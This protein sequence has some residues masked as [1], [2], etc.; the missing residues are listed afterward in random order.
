[1]IAEA[2]AL[3]DRPARAARE[4][5][6]LVA[7]T[8]DQSPVDQRQQLFK[9]YGDIGD[10][11][12]KEAL[13][14]LW[15]RKWLIIFVTLLVAGATAAIVYAMTPLYTSSVRLMF[16]QPRITILPGL[17]DQSPATEQMQVIGSRVVAE[18]VIDRLDLRFDPEFN[19]DLQ[20]E[21][22]VAEFIG[23]IRNFDLSAWV[24]PAIGSG[25]EI[26]RASDSEQPQI[27]PIPDN[28]LR[29][30]LV[31]EQ[32]VDAFL[33]RLTVDTVPQSNV[34][35]IS[36]ASLQPAK[37]AEIADAIANAYL[38]HRLE[39]KFE[40]IQRSSNWLEERIGEL[41]TQV[42]QAET[43]LEDYRR[44]SGLTESARGGEGAERQVAELNTQLILAR[45]DRAEREARRD[46][47]RRML[48]GGSE[49]LTRAAE[50]LNSPLVNSLL[51][52]QIELN[53]RVA[54]LSQIYGGRHPQLLSARAELEDM[55]QKIQQEARRVAEGL[56]AEV[57][58][59]RERERRLEQGL[60]E[61]ESSISETQQASVMLRAL[62]REANAARNLLETFLEQAQ[63][64]RSQ[65]DIG[66]QR[67]DA[68]IIAAAAIP[69]F[70]SYPRKTLALAA[71]IVVGG[72]LGVLLALLLERFDS[73]FRSAEQLEEMLGLPV[74][75]SIPDLRRNRQVRKRGLAAYLV[76]RPNS[77]AAEAIRALN[78][79]MMH[80][81]GDNR[82]MVVQFVSAE[83]EEGKSSLAITSAQQH[84]RAGRKV[85]LIDADFRQSTVAKTFAIA[86]SPGLS[87]VMAGRMPLAEAIRQ[88]RS[89]GLHLVTTGQAMPTSHDMLVGG[90]FTRL[91][92][93]A[94]ETYDLVIVDSPPV[95]SLTDASVI[96]G[97]VDCSIFV[98][99]W[100]K[101]RRQTAIYA[102][103]QLIAAGGTV[104]GAVLS[105]V[106]LKRAANYSYGDSE[107]Y[108]T[109]HQK[110]YLDK[111]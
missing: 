52:E 90:H 100:G 15:R 84:T 23:R 29:H 61:V 95:L 32:I 91:L 14:G 44:S 43:A 17:I 92:D 58:V 21:T 25:L 50:I 94:R 89:S 78:A 26:L 106:D 111:A 34:I 2:A 47:V 12:F 18:R 81:G 6:N 108:G 33:G 68:S 88:D 46:Q 1:L 110:Y 75:A 4:G 87:E 27:E 53:R 60:R 59:A 76:E 70:P 72:V 30:R 36:F 99:R 51:V 24:S 31:Q 35:E 98:T 20:P 37:A 105:F 57:A 54:D 40:E 66:T 42:Q 77:A 5:T 74:L 79:R 11:D 83:P 10:V 8:P 67:N 9:A 39:A 101:T 45:T 109:K 19:P 65:D 7:R 102:L 104:P 48:Q 96:G 107:R 55:E 97:V 38:Q 82:A 41:R 3:T 16:E 85:L 13:L 49:G 28:P 86:A 63:Q 64:L 93:E 56:D 71:A 80:L 69:R 62:E 73:V 22:A 103:K